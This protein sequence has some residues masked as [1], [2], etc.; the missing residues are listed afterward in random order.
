MNRADPLDVI[1]RARAITDSVVVGVSGGKDSIVAL[2]LCV[3]HFRRV[4]AYHLYI[5]P[6]LSFVETYL[7]YL[8]RRYKIHIERRPHWLL[9]HL[10]RHAGFR[11]LS[12]WSVPRLSI[13]DV[14]AAERER[15]GVEWCASGIK[16]IDSLERMAMLRV[17]GDVNEK[18]RLFYPLAWWRGA[19][20]HN[21][22]KANNIPLAPD[23]AA[24]GS[25]WNGKLEG[26][27]L[28]AIK[29]TWPD[30]YAKIEEAF[31][32][33]GAAVWRYAN[34]KPADVPRRARASVAADPGPE[35]PEDAGPARA[36]EAA[37]VDPA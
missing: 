6:D 34:L 13:R 15:T 12:R 26:R 19:A 10:M 21:H 14:E 8:E 2:D 23:Y 22:L 25:H 5:V 36:E 28:A 11:P 16:S 18:G 17:A 31:P 32:Y 20:V 24:L 33:V 37:R 4:E 30:D 27:E 35:Q 29:A 1:R 7:G 9:A 3:R